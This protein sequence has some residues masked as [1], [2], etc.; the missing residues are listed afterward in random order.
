M[1]GRREAPIAMA[2]KKK[3]T[4]AG[5]RR[6]GASE[7]PSDSTHSDTTTVLSM[8]VLGADRQNWMS[9]T[10]ALSM[11]LILPQMLLLRQRLAWQGARVWGGVAWRGVAR[12]GK[13]ARVCAHSTVIQGVTSMVTCRVAAAAGRHRSGAVQRTACSKVL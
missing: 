5:R 2:G 11:V 12:C 13:R 1:S 7:L 6:A 10:L 3:I 8:S 9:S 4:R